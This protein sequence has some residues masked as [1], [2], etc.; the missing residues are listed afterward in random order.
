MQEKDLQGR[1]GC[2]TNYV[3]RGLF[4]MDAATMKKTW[5][6]SVHVNSRIAC[7]A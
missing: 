5:T 6:Y 7:N 1:Y 4:G 3:Y 2:W